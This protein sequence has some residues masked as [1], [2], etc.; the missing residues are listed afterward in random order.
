MEEP[1]KII[2]RNGRRIR[3]YY[4]KDVSKPGAQERKSK[5]KE[6][7]KWCRGCEEWLPLEEVCRQCHSAEE[8]SRYKRDENFREYRKNQRDK[9]R[10]GVER[11]PVDAAEMLLEVFDG[12]CAYCERPATTWDHVIAVS[13][14]GET[15]AGNIVP[16]CS[17]CNS[18]KRDKDIDDWLNSY[19]PQVK[20]YTVEYLSHMGILR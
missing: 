11:V 19:A 20:E 9:R 4:R 7:V 14:G 6:G 8:R 15:S 3:F 17:S 2:D 12:E 16:A 18:S 13:L 10:R 1:T 5:L